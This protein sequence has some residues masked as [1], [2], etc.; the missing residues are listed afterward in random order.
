[1]GQFVGQL[2]DQPEAAALV[3]G[4]SDGGA[5]SAS[6]ART[7]TR[8]PW[9][10]TRRVGIVPARRIA[11]GQRH[12]SHALCDRLTGSGP[13][14]DGAGGRALRR[15]GAAAHRLIPGER[16]GLPGGDQLADVE[17]A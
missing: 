4:F 1:M 8:R 16:Q 9:T 13:V 2:I 11:A 6:T 3:N 5:D 10:A 17:R 7:M 15:I 12:P 14:H